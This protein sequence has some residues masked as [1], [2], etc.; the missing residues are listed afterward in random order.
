MTSVWQWILRY[1]SKITSNKRKK[2]ISQTSSKLK[3]T[4]CTS[5]DIIKRVKN[6]QNGRKIFVNCIKIEQDPAGPSRYKSLCFP[7]FLFVE[8]GFSFQALH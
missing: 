7:C 2:Y 5:K 3:K 1:D 8:R 4:F 6:P